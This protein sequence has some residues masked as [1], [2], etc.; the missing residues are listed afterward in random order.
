M[1]EVAVG[2]LGK[3]PKSTNQ[4]GRLQASYENTHVVMTLQ[5]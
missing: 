5:L 4:N 3:L 1:R 2:N